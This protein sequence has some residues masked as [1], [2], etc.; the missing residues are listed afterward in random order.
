[1]G[2]T[3][4]ASLRKGIFEPASEKVGQM[5]GEEHPKQRNEQ[6]PRVLGGN[7]PGGFEAQQRA[8]YSIINKESH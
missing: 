4:K 5:S 6:M 2:R 3:W 7:G 8:Q 1:M